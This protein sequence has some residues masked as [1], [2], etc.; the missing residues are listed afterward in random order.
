MF[1]WCVFCFAHAVL[2]CTLSHNACMS[3]SYTDCR[4]ISA[5]VDTAA[6]FIVIR[7]L[8]FEFF[9]LGDATV[10]PDVN[11]FAHSLHP[12]SMSQT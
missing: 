1:L 10:A 3:T 2:N 6:V 11:A 9:G 7:Q 12:V 5:A 8:C 4:V